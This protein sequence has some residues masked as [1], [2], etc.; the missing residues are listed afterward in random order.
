MLFI[1]YLVYAKH[2]AKHFACISKFNPH[3]NC[4]VIFFILY[5]KE[6]RPGITTKLNQNLTVRNWTRIYFMISPS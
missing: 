6:L 2:Y 3:S 4:I 1:Q 5:M